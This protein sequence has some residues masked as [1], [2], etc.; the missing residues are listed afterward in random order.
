MPTANVEALTERIYVSFTPAEAE[1]IRES[2]VAN[3]RGSAS[4]DIRFRVLQ[5]FGPAPAKKGGAAR[6]RK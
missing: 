5:T 3:G 4:A 1:R 6:K 2:A